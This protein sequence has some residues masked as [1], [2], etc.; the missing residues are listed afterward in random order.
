MESKLT[1]AL[2]SL[3]FVVGT[4]LKNGLTTLISFFINA[5]NVKI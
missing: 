3:N 2:L 4:T 5:Q 1:N